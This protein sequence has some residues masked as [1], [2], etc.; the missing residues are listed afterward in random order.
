MSHRPWEPWALFGL[1]Q[2]RLKEAKEAHL[3]QFWPPISSFPKMTKRTL[4]PKLAKNHILA[5]F[6]PWPLATTS[7]RPESFPLH[8]GEDSPSPIYSVPR[9]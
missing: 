3:S 5:I 4:G 9:I 8:S 1:N 7:S 6:N 2:M